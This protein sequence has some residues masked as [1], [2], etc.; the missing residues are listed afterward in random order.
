MKKTE[1]AAVEH[2]RKLADRIERGELGVSSLCIDRDYIDV[3]TDERGDV[4]L[5]DLSFEVK[6]CPPKR[7]I[8]E[9]ND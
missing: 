6:F 8:G 7:V 1:D 2:M 9:D 3:S 4:M 5:F